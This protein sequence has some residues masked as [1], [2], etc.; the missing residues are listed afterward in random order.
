[1]AARAQCVKRTLSQCSNQVPGENKMHR[2][3]GRG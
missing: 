3:N 1:M 2:V